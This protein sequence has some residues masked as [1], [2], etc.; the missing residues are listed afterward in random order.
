[1]LTV[2]ELKSDSFVKR[3]LTVLSQMRI[4]DH[5]RRLAVPRTTLLR[6]FGQPYD[7]E[8]SPC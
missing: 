5:Y 4:F 1:M 8:F 3:A 7:L 2:K 6:L